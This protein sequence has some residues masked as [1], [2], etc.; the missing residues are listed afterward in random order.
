MFRMAITLGI[1][2][3]HLMSGHQKCEFIRHELIH[4]HEA[5]DWVPLAK[6]DDYEAQFIQG[7]SGDG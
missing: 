7:R 3:Q 1:L 2:P 4:A 5:P 6:N